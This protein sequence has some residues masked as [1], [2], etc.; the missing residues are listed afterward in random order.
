MPDSRSTIR[1]WPEAE[2]KRARHSLCRSRSRMSFT[3]PRL[4]ASAALVMLAVSPLA[5]SGCLANPSPYLQQITGHALNI[6]SSGGSKLVSRSDPKQRRVEMGHSWIAEMDKVGSHWSIGDLAITDCRRE[7]S[8]IPDK[9]PDVDRAIDQ[10]MAE[11]Q[12][13]LNN[14][15]PPHIMLFVHGGRVGIEQSARHSAEV[16]AR[17][18]ADAEWDTTAQRK[19]A[20]PI[21]PIFLNWDTN[22]FRASAN[23]LA[24]V[25][26]GRE[27]NLAIGLATTPFV[28]LADLGRAIGRAPI[29]FYTQLSGLRQSVPPPANERSLRKPEGW[30][31]IQ[32]SQQSVPPPRIPA[33]A[34]WLV[35]ELLPGA[36]RLITIP[37]ADT[38]GQGAYDD[39]RRRARVLFDLDPDFD[40]GRFRSCGAVTRLM[41]ELRTLERVVLR[42]EPLVRENRLVYGRRDWRNGPVTDLRIASAARA[43]G[44]SGGLLEKPDRDGKRA[45]SSCEAASARDR[46]AQ[47]RRLRTAVH[48]DPATLRITLISHSMGGIV[49]NELI[50]RNDDLYFQDVVY[51]APANSVR[52]FAREALPYLRA[53]PLTEFHIF[54]LHPHRERTERNWLNVVPQGSLLTWVDRFLT[55]PNN[56]LD[57]TMGDWRNLSRTLTILDYLDRHERERINVRVFGFDESEP[58]THGQFDDLPSSR[59]GRHSYRGS[60]FWKWHACARIDRGDETAEDC[61]DAGDLDVFR[62]EDQV[63]WPRS[64]ECRP[65]Q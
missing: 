29:L 61:I 38:L 40:T 32:L 30:D 41:N 2:R 1:R 43:R 51:M 5:L 46:T 59:V 19:A 14:G 6:D 44:S 37:V 24:R 45:V 11:F 65:T 28:L 23:H 57:K 53:N 20:L 10:I 64:V 34:Q 49:A 18:R 58:Q 35:P 36:L 8:H 48:A 56:D 33:F 47:R 60:R 9:G 55:K 31:H 50:R 7:F 22:E 12:E 42:D 39:M 4:G 13:H 54:T 52:D 25:R 15:G 17:I 63:E 26:R 27:T 62:V 3:I 21:F 16:L